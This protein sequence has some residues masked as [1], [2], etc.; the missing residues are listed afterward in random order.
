MLLDLRAPIASEKPAYLGHCGG[1]ATAPEKLCGS[2]LLRGAV[3]HFRPLTLLRFVPISPI[4]AA[5]KRRYAQ[6][7]NRSPPRDSARSIRVHAA[8]LPAKLAGT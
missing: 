3:C 7:G 8:A 5:I 6:V 2:R 1:F 4:P